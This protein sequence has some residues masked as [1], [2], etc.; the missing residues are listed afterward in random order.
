MVEGEARFRRLEGGRAVDDLLASIDCV[1]F[2][3]DGVLWRGSVAIEGA[4]ETVKALRAMQ[5]R[6]LFVTNNSI[7]S[8]EEILEKFS[9]LGLDVQRD[10]VVT[11]SYLLAKWIG[12]LDCWDHSKHVYV[13]GRRGIFEELTSL[14]IKCFGGPVIHHNPPAVHLIA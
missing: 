7:K 10:E 8:R 3:C 12:G 13:I 2:D 6:L 4:V 9:S 1:I 14:N 11:T 5:K